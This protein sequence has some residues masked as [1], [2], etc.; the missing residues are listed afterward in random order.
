[1]SDNIHYYYLHTNGSLIHKPG[2]V[3]D[4]DPS[5]FHSDFVKAYWRCDVTDRASAWITVI[6]A[7]ALGADLDRIKE[8]STKWGLTRDELP[9]FLIRCPDP[10]EVQRKG[11]RLFITDVLGLDAEK[12]FDEIA[13]IGKQPTKG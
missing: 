13:A 5:Y 7:L 12:V 2:F 4:S 8:L 6:E 10:T 1:M 11:L 9:H 3:V